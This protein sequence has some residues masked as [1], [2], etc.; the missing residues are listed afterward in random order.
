M[1]FRGVSHFC[2]GVCS[3]GAEH[4]V[5][6]ID[7]SGKWL[8]EPSFLIAMEFSEGRAFVSDDGETFRIIDMKGRT[9]GRDYFER[10]RPFRAGLAPVMKD[11]LWGFVD[12]QGTTV[13]PFVFEDTR[14]QHFKTGLAAV[15]VER[16][17]GFIDRSGSFSINPYFEEVWPFAEGLASV[18]IDGRWGMVDLGG[19]VRLSPQWDELGQLVNGLANAQLDGKS[20]Y[21]DAT[22][23]WVIA[24]VYDKAKPFFGDLA[25]VYVGNAPAYV[26]VDRQ[27]VWQ[28]EPHAIVPRAPIP[29]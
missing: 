22:G 9:R 21:V 5:G 26:R 12:A 15:K 14:A 24:P 16:R 29:S 2:D 7:H 28:F 11:G 20:G 23:D 25:L 4:G 19:D 8:I 6:Y 1:L 27:L 17:W 18:K 3:I 10:A 13:I